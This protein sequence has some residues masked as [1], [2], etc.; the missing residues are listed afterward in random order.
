[1]KVILKNGGVY[2]TFKGGVFPVELNATVA[3]DRSYCLISG[4]ELNKLSEG[5][6]FDMNMFYSF[7]SAYFDIPI[8]QPQT[9]TY[10]APIKIKVTEDD[11]KYEV[12]TIGIIDLGEDSWKNEQYRYM[13][14]HTDRSSFFCD[15]VEVVL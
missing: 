10:H 14:F 12:D 15:N 3:N 4:S 1:M 11:K 13:V 5:I 8:L 2:G 6:C 9:V 7:S